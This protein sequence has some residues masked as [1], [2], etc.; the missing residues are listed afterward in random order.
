MEVA[1]IIAIVQAFARD[2]ACD[3]AEGDDDDEDDDEAEL[4]TMRA[5]VQQARR[6]VATAKTSGNHETLSRLATRTLPDLHDDVSVL[7]SSIERT[8]LL[9]IVRALRGG[10]ADYDEADSDDDGNA[11]TSDDNMAG[12]AKCGACDKT[13]SAFND[14][15]LRIPTSCGAHTAPRRTCATM[16]RKITKRLLKRWIRLTPS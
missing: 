14:V 1:P 8:S 4:L 11:E 3:D 13:V 7:A 5:A 2:V 6:D 12:P 9:A 15:R 10:L 16:L